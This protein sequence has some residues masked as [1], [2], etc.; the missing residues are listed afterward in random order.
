MLEAM[1]LL[2][3]KV[4]KETIDKVAEDFGMPM[5]P[6]ELADT[7]GLD[8]CLAVGDSLRARLGD[9]LPATPDWLREK[10]HNG[11]LGRKTGKGFYSWKDGKAQKMGAMTASPNGAQ[12]NMA[13]N[14]G[15]ANLPSSSEMAD[16]LIL[17]GQC[18]RRLSA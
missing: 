2:D 8:I 13:P 18:L 7:V 12:S 4:P 14:A 15:A 11:E 17:H 3:Q 10:V 6:I 16:R 1:M 9:A 5:G